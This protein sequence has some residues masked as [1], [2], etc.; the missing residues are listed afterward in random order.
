MG[1]IGYQGIVS[2]VSSAEF[3]SSNYVPLI[4]LQ[5]LLYSSPAPIYHLLT[6]SRKIEGSSRTF[7]KLGRS[8]P[9]ASLVA[10]NKPLAPYTCQ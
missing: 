1:S 7:N 8:T 6:Y 3:I 4:C 10:Y 9:L 2:Q 5:L